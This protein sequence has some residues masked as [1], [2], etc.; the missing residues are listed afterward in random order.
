MTP[1]TLLKWLLRAV[2]GVEVF[3]VPFI[4][5]PLAWMAAVHDKLLGLGPL[6]SEPIVEYMARCLSAVYAVHGAVVFALSF[7]V[8][9]YRPLVRLVGGLHV[10][11]GACVVFTDVS[12]G[13][14]LLWVV[15]EGP[16]IA[17]GGV[18][19]LLLSWRRTGG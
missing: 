18:L 6:P 19:I 3:A 10:F 15:V 8:A 12:A 2:G 7:D 5:F 4:F 16:G 11:L 13:F 1:D 9:R 14:P 17:A